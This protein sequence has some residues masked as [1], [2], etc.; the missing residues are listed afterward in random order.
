MANKSI[1]KPSS[2]ASATAKSNL[3]LPVLLLLAV[4][5]FGLSFWGYQ[6]TKSQLS[7]LTNPD[8]KTELNQQQTEAL[9]AKVSKLAVLPNEK[10]PVVATINDVEALSATQDFYKDANNGDRL[11]IFGHSRTAIIY[12]EAHHKIVNIGPIFYTDADGNNQPANLIEDGRITIDLRNG[13][14]TG[15]LGITTRDSLTANYAFNISRLAKAANS[16]YKGVTLVKLTTNE[17][18]AELVD[19]LAKQL[20]A[21]IV[22]AMPAG[23]TAPG[24]A[25]VVVILGAK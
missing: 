20:G 25:E 18:K 22:T 1:L 19:A 21:T 10:N 13:S 5:A 15:D 16:D 8:Q 7:A 11:I 4:A 14:K 9:L 12:D 2:P 3:L 6:Q 17:A 24:T 23:E